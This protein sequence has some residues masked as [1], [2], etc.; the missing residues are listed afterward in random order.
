MKLVQ[1][2]FVAGGVVRCGETTALPEMKRAEI[3]TGKVIQQIVVSQ[4]Y[5]SYSGAISQL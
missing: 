3:Y 5:L 2:L 1:N 4:L